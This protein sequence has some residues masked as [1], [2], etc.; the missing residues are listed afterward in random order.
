MRPALYK[1]MQDEVKYRDAQFY[2]TTT[3]ES[4]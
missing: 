2:D 1:V 3:T 4:K